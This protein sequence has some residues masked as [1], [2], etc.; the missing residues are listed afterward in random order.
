MS[1]DEWRAVRRLLFLYASEPQESLFDGLLIGRSLP[2]VLPHTSIWLLNVQSQSYELSNLFEPAVHQLKINLSDSWQSCDLQSYQQ[3]L[4]YI[5]LLSFDAAIVLTIPN[6]SPFS[7]A[8]L[9]YL[10]GIP[11][12]WGQSQEF[13]GRVLSHCI[14]PPQNSSSSTAYLLHL[15]QSAGLPMPHPTE[16]EWV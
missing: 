14:Q 2:L 15:L 7:L 6:R 4:Q 11:I 9:C 5:K 13:G 16:L 3:L 10:A 8:Y 1:P 12:R